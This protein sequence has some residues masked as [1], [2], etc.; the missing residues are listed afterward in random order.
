MYELLIEILSG[1]NEKANKLL[2]VWGGI[3]SIISAIAASLG[4]LAIRRFRINNARNSYKENVFMLMQDISR[5]PD[6]SD[7]TEDGKKKIRRIVRLI[8]ESWRLPKCIMYFTE[9][10]RTMRNISNALET[11]SDL[12]VIKAHL[13]AL[14]HLEA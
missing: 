2:A 13:S 14:K 9:T 3:A 5:L 8:T 12:G 10:A 1:N 11:D 6:D 4:Y 7:L